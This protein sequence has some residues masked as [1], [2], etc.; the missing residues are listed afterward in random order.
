MTASEPFEI[1]DDAGRCIGIA[2]R[3]HVHRQGL[4]HRAAHVWL[5]TGDGRLWIQRRAAHKDVCPGCWDF[6]VGE[7]LRP[8]ERF[9]EAAQR[10]LDEELG[11]AG[12][13]LAPLGGTRR[14]QHEDALRGIRD[15]EET[16]AFRGVWDGSV[17]P[18]PAEVDAVLA[19]GL[20][21]LRAW[22]AREPAAFTPWF[23]AESLA[24]GML[25]DGD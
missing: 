4:W 16:Q 5:F 9:D 24:L 23:L 3:R 25:R 21:E 20:A 15:W 11:V 18:D 22:V 12:I 6:S 1:Y 2:A 7:H 8:G 17:E 10:G 14:A 13:A 19:I